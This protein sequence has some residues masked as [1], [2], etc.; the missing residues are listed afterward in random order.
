[1]Q[2]Y[3]SEILGHRM[4]DVIPI[5]CV[6]S[7]LSIYFFCFFQSRQHDRI[8]EVGISSSSLCGAV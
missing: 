5:V 1:M 2:K 3:S 4:F 7:Y 8:Q 6:T